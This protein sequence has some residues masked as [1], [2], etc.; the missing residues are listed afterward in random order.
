MYIPKI[1]ITQ[2]FYVALRITKALSSWKS[3]DEALVCIERFKEHAP[4]EFSTIKGVIKVSREGR[5][6]VSSN[7]LTELLKSL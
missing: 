3:L 1:L 4:Y 5:E 2:R 7:E 6:W